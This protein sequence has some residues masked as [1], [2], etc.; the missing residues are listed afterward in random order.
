[1]VEPRECRCREEKEK[2]QGRLREESMLEM[3]R[4]RVLVLTRFMIWVLMEI[5]MWHLNG[6]GVVGLELADV[7]LGKA[8]C[9]VNVGCYLLSR[10]G[11]C[12][13][14]EAF[15]VGID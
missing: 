12:P 14:L 13:R 15:G 1:M 10:D 7:K 3:K 4:V 9:G 5:R 2:L 8:I 6:R 11:I